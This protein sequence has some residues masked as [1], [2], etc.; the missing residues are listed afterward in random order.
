MPFISLDWTMIIQ[1]LN[2][3]VLFLLLRKFLFAPVKAMIDSREAEV[4]KIYTDAEQAKIDAERLKSEYAKSM[5]AARDEAEG[6]VKN[7]QKNAQVRSD[8]IV[9]EAQ[10]RA[11]R[12]LEKAETEIQREKKKAVNEIK[13]EISDIAIMI[14]EKVVEREIN[15]HDHEKLIAEFI[16]CVGE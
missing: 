6:I 12:M 14:A 4:D 9:A 3:L 8:E 5:A 16:D 11:T 2:T 7:A 1:L 13:D 10:A 15:V